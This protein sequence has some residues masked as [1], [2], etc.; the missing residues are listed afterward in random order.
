MTI[1]TVVQEACVEALGMDRPSLVFGN[2]DRE[3][4]EMQ[5]VVNSAA[6]MICDA[7][8]WQKLRAIKTITGD[9]V[10]EAFPLPDDY[11]RMLKTAS[12]WSSR[13]FWS[14]NHITDADQWLELQ[15]VPIA[16]TYGNWI[17]YGDEMH[18]L[19][20]MATGETGKYFYIRNLRVLDGAATPKA[21]FTADTDTFRLSENLLKLAII[22][23]W[24]QNKGLPY[25]EA[26][27]DY[28]VDLGLQ[29]DK[30]QGSKPIVSAQPWASWRGKNI[31]WPG[32]VTGAP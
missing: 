14:I 12:L 11:D 3:M 17:I 15:V 1:L 26:M 10:T 28:Q 2:Q 19:P 27:E 30:D 16:S 31:A 7:F 25:A 23:R 32:S 18:I 20:L 9:D 24:K 22:Y 13:W 4:V 6:R 29:M 5:A 8:D 21:L